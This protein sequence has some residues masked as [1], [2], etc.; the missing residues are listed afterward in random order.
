[1]STLNGVEKYVLDTSQK[2]DISK[3]LANVTNDDHISYEVMV[4]R[5][6]EVAEMG[7]NEFIFIRLHIQAAEL[8][9]W[10]RY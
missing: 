5:N 8:A 9:D 2:A 7:K 6:K 1:M 3:Y 4:T 10:V